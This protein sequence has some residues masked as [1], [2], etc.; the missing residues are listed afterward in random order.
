MLLGLN[1]WCILPAIRFCFFLNLELDVLV[2]FAFIYK[3]LFIPYIFLEK[4]W[5]SAGGFLLL[6]VLPGVDIWA[7]MLELCIASRWEGCMVIYL[8]IVLI[9]LD[10]VL[11]FRSGLTCFACVGWG[12]TTCLWD[13]LTP[14]VWQLDVSEHSALLDRL[15]VH[16]IFQ[17]NDV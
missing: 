14:S 17:M 10:G 13:G 1:A 6:N 11:V 9:C 12:D 4:T 15:H 3:N 8:G 7:W 16:Y 5:Y 2:S